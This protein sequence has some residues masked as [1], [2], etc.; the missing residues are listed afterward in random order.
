LRRTTIFQATTSWRPE[1]LSLR[2]MSRTMAPTA[3]YR[4]R[5][6]MGTRN[7]ISQACRIW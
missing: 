3:S 7:G 2:T 4:P 6:R 5:L 1:G